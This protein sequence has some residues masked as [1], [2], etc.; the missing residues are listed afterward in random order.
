MLHLVALVFLAAIVRDPRLMRELE[1]DSIPGPNWSEM[2]HVN[3]ANKMTPITNLEPT[4]YPHHVAQPRDHSLIYRK[5][6]LFLISSCQCD[7]MTTMFIT[8]DARGVAIGT[9]L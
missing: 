9:Y 5:S 6:L 4:Q 7:A 3:N 1:H 8:Q 2:G